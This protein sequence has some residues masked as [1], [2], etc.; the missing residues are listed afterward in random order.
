MQFVCC[1]PVRGCETT[2]HARLG[3]YQSEVAASPKSRRHWQ[4]LQHCSRVIPRWRAFCFAAGV[5]RR[6]WRVSI[7]HACP[8]REKWLV[9]REDRIQ[10][11]CKSVDLFGK[12]SCTSAVV[13]LLVRLSSSFVVELLRCENIEELVG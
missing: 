11:L 10:E 4:S 12:V 1:A 9:G 6:R 2:P 7:F 8:R 13:S 5:P 3:G